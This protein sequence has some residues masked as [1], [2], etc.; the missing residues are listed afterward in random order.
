M[1]IQNINYYYNPYLNLNIFT[2][3][4]STA[5]KSGGRYSRLVQL[6][7][8]NRAELSGAVDGTA[9]LG[10]EFVCSWLSFPGAGLPLDDYLSLSSLLRLRSA[11]ASFGARRR[12][13]GSVAGLMFPLASQPEEDHRHYDNADSNQRYQAQ[14]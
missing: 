9:A 6:V 10:T 12:S 7:A 11:S 5:L 14:G 1:K 4:S 3:S 13:L 8:A 2:A